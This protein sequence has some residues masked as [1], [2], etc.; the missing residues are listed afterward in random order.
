MS[1]T[2][3]KLLIF[4]LLLTAF[5]FQEAF[6][7][8]SMRSVSALTADTSGWILVKTAAASSKNR[9]I[10][11]PVADSAKAA[12]ALYQMQVTTHSYM[13]AV[14]YFTGGLLIDHCW[15]RLLGSGSNQL[16]RTLPNWNKSR[17]FKEF[18]E[19]PG[20]LL[21]GDD[22]IG[23]FFAVNGGALGPDLGNVFYLAPETL[24]WESLGKSYSDFVDFC[25]N[26]D[27]NKFYKGYRWPGWE[28]ETETIKGDSVYN[29]YPFLWTKE[30][31]DIRKDTRKLVPVEEQYDFNLDAIKRL[32][33]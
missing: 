23:G 6:A 9:A 18:G 25:L 20:Y 15:I 21:I 5:S 12:E 32:I 8:I 24:K 3:T 4:L 10:I 17:T 22:V 26:G 14:I 33:R 31:Q 2:K 30:G 16:P 13:G 1:I 28:K 29:F 19:R 11:L 27:L 7:Q